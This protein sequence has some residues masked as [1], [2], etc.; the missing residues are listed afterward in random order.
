MLKSGHQPPELYQEL[1][2]TLNA[3]QEWRGKLCNKNKNG[4]VYWEAASMSPI[5]NTSGEITWFLKV[6]EDITDQKR[7][8]EIVLL[9]KNAIETVKI[10]IMITD[11]QRKIIYTNLAEASMHGYMVEELIG[12]DVRIFSSEDHWQEI[13]FTRLEKNWQ[14]ESLNVRKDGTTFPVHS[15][16]TPVRNEVGEPIGIITVSKDIT[17]RRRSE[18][19]LRHAKEAAEAANRAK[20][21]FLANM[22]HELRT[23]LNAILGYA[24]I[25]S[26]D[27]SL[28][29]KQSEGVDIIRRSGAH[30]L[31]MINDILD[32]SKIEAQKLELEPT[33]FYFPGFLHS[34][35]DMVRIRANN[36]GIAFT[37][38]IAQDIPETIYADE[39]RLRQILLN[40][41][42][43]AIKFTKEGG[44]SLRVYELDEFNELENSK[45]QKTLRF[46]V[47]DTGV[48]IPSEHLEK[49]FQPFQQVS[50]KQF[51][52]EGTGLG[53]AISQKLLRAMGS[54]LHVKSTPGKGSLFWLDLDVSIGQNVPMGARESF[55]RIIGFKGDVRTILIVDD[56]EE[57]RNVLKGMLLPLGFDILEAVNG[58]EAIETTQ[59]S[60]PDLIFMDL[61]MPEMD[62]F[63]AT[64][65]IRNEELRPVLG[66]VEGMKNED[67]R[68]KAEDGITKHETQVPIIAVSASAFTRTLQESL[69]AGCHDFLAKPF[70]QEDLL[71]MLRTYLKL[72]W[73]YAGEEDR[74]DSQHAEEPIIPPPQDV[75]LELYKLAR[76]GDIFTLQNRI[77]EFD[78]LDPSYSPFMTKARYLAKELKLLEIQQ[79]F[80]QYLDD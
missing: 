4:E 26:R 79:F 45:T 48:G 22:S 64:K 9:L 77:E 36:E 59:N 12:E 25:F 3:G 46:E 76:I 17:E 54:K 38:N 14:R 65:R 63:E 60:H 2:K 21:E 33:E 34:M 57:N 74:R 13:E 11:I 71:E 18:E 51:R 75:L 66:D 67:R 24:Q 53:L 55:R 32:L 37:S 31:T 50:E 29:E 15:I 30:L 35:A 80:K 10:G 39:K 40:L 62:G 52:S 5:R 68:Q 6:A 43:N 58:R 56:K 70:A 47:E 19:E 41:L 73:L 8:E 78:T 7:A 49:I 20:S 23:P 16:S 42:S 1:W 72:E 69:H 28:T 44:I 61:I 27:Q